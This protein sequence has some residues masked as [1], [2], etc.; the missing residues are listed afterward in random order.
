VTQ[1][2]LFAQIDGAFRAG[3]M[4]H[5][6]DLCVE[7][8]CMPKRGRASLREQQFLQTARPLTTHAQG[9]NLRGYEWGGTGERVLLLHGWESQ[10]SRW[11]SAIP[12]FVN[13]GL[14]V[15]AFD[16]PAHGDSDG[17][18]ANMP[19]YA[20][21]IND[22]IVQHGP[23]DHIVGHSFGAQAA[24]YHLATHHDPRVKKLAVFGM[25]HTVERL[26]DN[27]FVGAN[28][29]AELRLEFDAAFQRKFGASLKDFAMANYSAKL[30]LP[31]LLI[32]DRDD[33]LADFDGA[34]QVAAAW[35]NCDFVSIEGV[36]HFAMMR[37][38]KVIDPI[39]QFLRVA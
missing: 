31:G 37:S 25:A 10:A 21:C 18:Q 33:A 30:K 9:L 27:F 12:L 14:R 32:Q 1:E 8:F 11:S 34:R 16:A 22:I 29:P 26:A 15:T 28:L 36:G 20:A 2:E 13:A 35:K 3:K 6:A 19:L 5:A 39:V 38:A 24:I 7:L 17:E 4:A 23:Y